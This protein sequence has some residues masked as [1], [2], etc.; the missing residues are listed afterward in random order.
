[1]TTEEWEEFVAKYGWTPYRWHG[2]GV[3]HAMRGDCAN[4]TRAVARLRESL[5]SLGLELKLAGSGDAGR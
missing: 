2:R 4:V 1:V 3:Q 5:A